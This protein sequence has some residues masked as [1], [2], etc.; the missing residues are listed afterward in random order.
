MW[1]SA[2]ECDGAFG[3]LLVLWTDVGAVVEHPDVG[4]LW[5]GGAVV[6]SV[7]ALVG[8]EGMEDKEPLARVYGELVL[9]DAVVGDEEAA[10]G[11]LVGGEDVGCEEVVGAYGYCGGC[12]IGAEVVGGDEEEGNGVVVEVG[13]MGYAGG[14]AGIDAVDV[15]LEVGCVGGT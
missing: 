11:G 15:P 1:R 5:T 4:G 12:C 9:Y 3:G 13:G 7:P 8:V 14:S 2:E 6:G 10:V